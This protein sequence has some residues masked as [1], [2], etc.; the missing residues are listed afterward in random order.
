MNRDGEPASAVQ[1]STL[2]GFVGVPRL[3]LDV[4]GGG[5]ISHEIMRRRGKLRPGTW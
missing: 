4:G 1:L 2:F 3:F 5:N